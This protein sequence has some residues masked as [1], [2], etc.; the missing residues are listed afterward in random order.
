MAIMSVVGGII[1][2]ALLIWYEL[3]YS[4]KWEI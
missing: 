4:R 2:C 3:G 1:V